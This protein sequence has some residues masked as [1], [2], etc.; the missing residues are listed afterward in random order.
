M[1]HNTSSSST[2]L[3]FYVQGHHSHQ[4]VGH[5]PGSWPAAHIADPDVHFFFGGGG[6]G[7]GGSTNVS[8]HSPSISSTPTWASLAAYTFPHVLS[9]WMKVL[10]INPEF[11]ILR[12][13]FHRK[14]ASI[15]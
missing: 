11:R 6:G 5:F 14:I 13:T 7:G 15:C 2:V 4:Y 3:F 10:R 1:P 9:T 12:L 8:F